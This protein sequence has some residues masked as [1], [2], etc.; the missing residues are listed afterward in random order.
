MRR[1]KITG[2]LSTSVLRLFFCLS[3]AVVLASCG[4]GDTQK[5]A[6]AGTDTTKRKETDIATTAAPGPE[7]FFT[8]EM[9]SSDLKNIIARIDNGSPNKRKLIFQ[10]SCANLA[11]VQG[12]F[13]LAVYGAKN[14]NDYA[15]ATKPFIAK[16]TAPGSW[17]IEDGKQYILGNNEKLVSEVEALLSMPGVTKII[18]SPF[19]DANNQLR[20]TTIPWAGT[21]A[22]VKTD[23][24]QLGKDFNSLYFTN[25][26]P[27]A[28]PDG[29]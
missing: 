19:V 5:G 11:A 27:P 3:A 8:V 29:Q 26:S 13:D 7:Y 21:E 1:V 16:A 25:P 4:S 28:K 2:N 6:N 14:H 15:E 22:L 23:T 24:L 20:Y 10:F 18:F 9:A 17:V 12:C